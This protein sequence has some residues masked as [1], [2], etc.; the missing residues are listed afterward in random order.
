MEKAG[1]M[2]TPITIFRGSSGL[3]TRDDPARLDVNGDLTESGIRQLSETNNVFVEES[4]RISRRTGYSRS[5][6]GDYHSLFCRGG[7]AYCVKNDYL[8]KIN[9][10]LTATQIRQLTADAKVSYAYARKD[11]VYY[12]NGHEIGYLVDGTNYT[13][14]SEENPILDS[15]KDF[16]EPPVGHIIR[17]KNGR[18]WIASGDSLWPSMR[19]FL[20]IYWWGWS[21]PFQSKIT[22]VAPVNDGIWV[23][24]QQSIY[25][26]QGLEP[27]EQAQKRIAPYPAIEGTAV[28]VENGRVGIVEFIGPGLSI[29]CLTQGGICILGQSGF[30]MNTTEMKI[31]PLKNTRPF[32]GLQGAATV[33]DGRYIATIEP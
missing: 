5:S 17:Y 14:E 26:I 3:N 16:V 15:D 19:M 31:D 22:M 32:V 28:E 8:C 24:D 12:A 23:S 9:P 13:W 27:G 11:R 25:W 33:I 20:G 29:M 30:F 6:T 18:M 10:D 1:R 21:I 4:G 7:Q 2:G